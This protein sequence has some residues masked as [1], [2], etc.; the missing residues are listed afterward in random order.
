MQVFFSAYRVLNIGIN[1]KIQAIH[2]STLAQNFL[3][4][5]HMGKRATSLVVWFHEGG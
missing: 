5:S 4:L 1:V 3:F 2:G